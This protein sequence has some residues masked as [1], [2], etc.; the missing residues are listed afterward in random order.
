MFVAEES[1]TDIFIYP[2]FDNF[3]VDGL[4]TNFHLPKSSLFL[5]ISAFIGSEMAMK[6]YLH[7]IRNEYLF[8]S[9][10]DACLFMR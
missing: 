5:L 7:A 10:G 6:A 2:P 8:Y 1:S 3:V 4:I 9:F